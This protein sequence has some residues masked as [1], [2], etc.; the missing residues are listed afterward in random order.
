MSIPGI[1]VAMVL[2]P[3]NP[4]TLSWVLLLDDEIIVQ[5]FFSTEPKQHMI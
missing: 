2:A 3:V 1:V 5:A 4:D